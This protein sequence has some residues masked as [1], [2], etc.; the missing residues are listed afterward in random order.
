M[1]AAE[2]RHWWY[3]GMQYITTS[4]LTQF[5]PSRTDLSILDSGCGTG[6]AM[7]YLSPFGLVT[8]C[9]LALLALQFCRQRDLESLSRATVMWLPFS[10]QALDL[11]T[12]FDVHYHRDVKDRSRAMLE[13]N[14]VLKPGGRVFLRLAAY[15]WMRGAHDR[16]VHTAHRF[17]VAEVRESLLSA[18]FVVERVSYANTIL[19]PLAMIQR[20]WESILVTE[21]ARSDLHSSHSWANGFLA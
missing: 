17:T 11:V 2:D 19:F 7:L 21:K 10:G 14:R 1:F 15:D 13:Y 4:L 12:S 6:A 9:D 5:Y 18:G 3:K 20:L 16:A 8:G